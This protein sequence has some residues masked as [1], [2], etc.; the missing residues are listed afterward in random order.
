MDP[1]SDRRA[2]PGPGAAARFGGP[3]GISRAHAWGLFAI[4]LLLTGLADW[5]SRDAW[6]G[7]VYL[8]IIGFASW[9]L[10][11]REAFA[12]GLSCMAVTIAVNGWSFYPYGTVAALWNLGVRFGAVAVTIGLLE[13]VRRSYVLQWRLARMDPLTGALNRQA[14]FETLATTHSRGWS[15]LAYLDLDGFKAL[16]DTYGHA[17]GD[18]SLRDFARRVRRLIRKQDIFARIGGDEFLIHMD[19]KDE[20]AAR[21]VAM[22][23][24]LAMNSPGGAAATG[25]LRCSL[26]VLILPAGA[27]DIDREV[28]LADRLMYDAKQRGASIE[29]ATARFRDRTLEL[30]READPASGCGGPEVGIHEVPD[31]ALGSASARAAA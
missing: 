8:L 25:R 14:F 27:R 13:F 10:G 11:W 12:I 17:A 30:V 15:L 2:K 29:V 16:N 9:S 21:Q 28:R 19:V 3:V 7:P 6:F 4:A 22:R 26:G 23:L 20:A 18:E 31:A 5:G 1:A 24:H